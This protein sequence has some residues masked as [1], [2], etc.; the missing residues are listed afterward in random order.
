L[1]KVAR[2]RGWP[3]LTFEKPVALRR[4]VAMPPAKPTLTAV[5]L[6]AALAVIGAAWW[7]THRKN[8]A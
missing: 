8:A 4:D 7:R 1:R 2:E 3:V 6:S 5:G